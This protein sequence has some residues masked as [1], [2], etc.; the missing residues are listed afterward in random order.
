[1]PLTGDEHP[2]GDFGPDGPHPPFRVGVRS[3]ASRRDLH[4]VDPRTRQHRAGRLSE[5]ARPVPDHEP[6]PV[7]VLPQI[8]QQVPGRRYRPRPVRARGDAGHRHVPGADLDHDEYVQAFEG[9]RTVEVEEIKRPLIR[10][11]ST[12]RR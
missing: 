4:D 5:L 10:P 11:S 12:F 7:G 2:V 3:W 9:D 8:H 1:M 6:A